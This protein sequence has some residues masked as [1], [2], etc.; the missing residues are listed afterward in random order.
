MIV[1][2][3]WLEALLGRPLEARELE[4]RLVQLGVPVEAIVPLHQDL[5]DILVARVLEVQPHPNADRLTLCSVDPGGSGGPVAVVCGAPNVQTGK[6]YPYAPVG[7]VLPGGFK[8]ERKKIRGVESNGM[9]CSAKELGLGEDQAGILELDTPAAPGV[10]LLDALPLA[11]DQLVLEV[12][13][14]RPDLLCHKGVARELAAVLGATV[15][16]PP[17]PGAPSPSIRPSVRQSDRGVVDG[18]DLRLEDAEGCPRYMAAVIRGVRVGPSPGWLAER[19]RAVGQRP[20]N[21]VVDAT[22]YILFELNQPLHAFDLGKLRGPAVVIRRARSGERI[23]TLDGV[24]RTL[25]ADMTA[26]CDAE[27]PTI[28]AGVMGSADSEVSEATTDLVLECAYFQ[29][30]R[31]RRTRRALALSS[32]SSYRFE[33]GIDLLGMP[34]ALRRATE[35]ILAVAGGEVREPPLDLW[36]RPEQPRVVFLRP[37]RVSHLLGVEIAR[38]EIERLLS[39]VGFVAAPKDDRLAVQVP[40]WRP[41]VTRDVDLI[42]EVARLRGYD[43]FPDELRPY[44]P[45]TVPDAPEE[46]AKARVRATLVGAGLLEAWTM[47]LGPAD[48]PD[49]VTVL[50]PLSAEEAH[51]RR[52]MLPGLVRRVQ[53]NWA[54]SVRDVRLFEVGAVF[55]TADGA[56]SAPEE[57]LSVAGVVTGA[58]RPPHWSEG[59][60]VPDMDIW[61][62]KYHFELAVGMASPGALLRPAPDGAGWEA[63]TTAGDVV[64]WGGAIDVD[65][66]KWAAPVYG[67]EV[68][69][70][71][72]AA[73][74][75]AYRPL[76]ATPPVMVDLALVLPAGVS[77]AAVEAVL[78][79][80]AGPLLVRLEV[81]SDYRG[82]GVPAGSRSV[83][84]HCEFRD[85]VRTLRDKDVEQ[86]VA[87]AL[88]ALE[89]ELDVRRRERAS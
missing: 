67:F 84:W 72:G 34:D 26:I 39:S 15:K 46:Q 17:I 78:R 5:G 68:R 1:S 60:K 31:I 23:V 58:R 32:E 40:G 62:L 33:R 76:P 85:P 87:K 8:L 3:R 59:A 65:V 50:N 83:A 57:Y 44:R 36:P 70:A 27:R 18:V 9:L 71:V 24:P 6:K 35:L 12:T 79:R 73:P 22:N 69:L 52:R 7:A 38:A 13:A 63:A 30:T 80:E 48:G 43:S 42:E 28:V 75:V 14:N 66:P 74:H 64:G 10:R 4:A 16:L 21:N 56:G 29:P 89:G 81:L 82:A 47:S 88:G 86:I 53:H 19:L 2:R 11:D 20:I 25:T 61:D 49:A 37:A 51:L 45:G 54:G 55:H 41:D 77:V